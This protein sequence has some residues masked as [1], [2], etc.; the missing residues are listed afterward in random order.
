MQP[1]FELCSAYSSSTGLRCGTSTDIGFLI[2]T[3]SR[4]S[5]HSEPRTL[6]KFLTEQSLQAP[7]YVRLGSA[8]PQLIRRWM[9]R[10]ARRPRGTL[11]WHDHGDDEHIEAYFGSRQE[12]ETIR[13]WEDIKIVRPTDTPVQLDHGYDEQKAREEIS[14]NDVQEAARFRGGECLS[15]DMIRG[16]WHSLLSW[17][18]H[19]GH[20]FSASLNLILMGGHW[21]PYCIGDPGAYSQLAQHSCFFNQVWAPDL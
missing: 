18:C 20:E 2:P 21:C 14:I 17:R 15:I 19:A 3:N 12:W 10:V 6:D 1:A 13:G 5:C 11:Y 7:W 4:R 8:I 16:D 9:E